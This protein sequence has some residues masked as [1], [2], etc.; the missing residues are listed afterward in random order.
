MPLVETLP[1]LVNRHERRHRKYAY[2]DDDDDKWRP[3]Q[4]ASGEMW[5]EQEEFE[6][7]IREMEE[8][9]W[10]LE[11]LRDL[12]PDDDGWPSDDDFGLF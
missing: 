10:M 2:E 4:E 1:E 11:D 6:H 9:R 3:I 12:S 5:Q 8:W 7:F